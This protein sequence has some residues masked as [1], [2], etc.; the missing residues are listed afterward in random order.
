MKFIIGVAVGW[1]IARV[2]SGQPL[3]PTEAKRVFAN[4]VH[5]QLPPNVQSAQGYLP[6]RN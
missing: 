5:E 6:Y 2:L 4:I 1:S 3:I